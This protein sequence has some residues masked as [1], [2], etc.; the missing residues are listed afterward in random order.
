MA[1]KKKSNPSYQERYQQRIGR[2]NKA[3]A[4]KKAADP[5]KKKE[6][7]SMASVLRDTL[8]MGKA[9]KLVKKAAKR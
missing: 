4:A 2:H 6:T 1:E 8:G 5:P 7:K 3:A 9:S